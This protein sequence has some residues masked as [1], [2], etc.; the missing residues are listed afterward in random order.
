[1]DKG[2]EMRNCTFQKMKI[3]VKTTHKKVMSCAEE[4]NGTDRRNYFS[5]S[6][7]P[8]KEELIFGG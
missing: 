8:K 2:Q 3:T 4:N 7:F 1:M 6:V 5:S